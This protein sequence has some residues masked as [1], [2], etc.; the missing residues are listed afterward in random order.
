MQSTLLVNEVFDSIQGEGLDMGRLTTFVRLSGCN[1]RCSW[2]DTA[3]AQGHD[4]TEMTPQ[5][6]ANLCGR[7][8]TFTGGEPMLQDIGA[9]LECVGM[10]TEVAV[11]TNGTIPPPETWKHATEPYSAIHWGVAPKPPSSG[12]EPMLDV[13]REFLREPWVQLKWVFASEDDWRF[14]LHTCVA[15]GAQ[16]PIVLQPVGQRWREMAMWGWGHMNEWFAFDARLIPQWHVVLWG[17]E[18]CR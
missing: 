16:C 6:V 11:E 12:H 17:Q 4:G 18:R 7:R 10:P 5:Q 1:L 3:Y 13:V 9:V 14:A 15:L 8:V 2:C